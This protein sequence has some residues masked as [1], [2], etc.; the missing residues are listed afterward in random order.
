M[1]DALSG[2]RGASLPVFDSA[3]ALFRTAIEREGG[4][5]DIAAV[6]KVVESNNLKEGIDCVD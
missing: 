3:A 5:E 4:R 6:I 1:A 2:E